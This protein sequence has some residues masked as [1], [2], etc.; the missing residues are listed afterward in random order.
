MAR[1]RE[2]I[3]KQE[4]MASLGMLTAG[5]AHEI[6]NPLNFVINFSKMSGKLLEDLEDILSEGSISLSE[7]DR[8]ELTEI[9]E[10]LKESVRRIAE[11][12]D[13]A[14]SI[15]RNILLYSRGKEDEYLPTDL[16]R[17]TKE[18]VSLSYH[19]MRA[20]HKNF[21]V[22]FEEDYDETLPQVSV[23]PQ[24]FS[25]AVLNI[26]NNAC[27]AVFAKSR[28]ATG[29]GY[30]PTIRISLHKDGDSARLVIEDNGT[31]I[32]PDI[33]K[34][35]FTPFFTTKPVGEGTGL[36]LSITKSIIEQKHHG[37]IKV[38]SEPGQY[39]RFTISIPLNPKK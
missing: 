3:A 15:I 25:R 26:M 2:Q 4:K 13:R 20:N 28:G 36:G 19:A 14:S 37:T 11:N 24:D 29:C 23:I 7:D 21:N 27:Y 6:Q 22:T 30:N 8:E 1:L 18:Y 35:L 9:M 34:H 17:L 10:D 38:E 39:S 32:S 31:G 16:C 5:I 12:G 33:R